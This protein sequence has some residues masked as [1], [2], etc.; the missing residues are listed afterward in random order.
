MTDRL[1]SP[2]TSMPAR[3]RA[4]LA[5][6]TIVITGAS[7]G[8]GRAAVRAFAAA[9]A[10]VMMVGRNEAKTAAAARTLMGETGSRE[11]HWETADLSRQ[12][13]VRE[14]A[15]RL[16]KRLPSIDVLINNAGALYL[17]RELTAEGIERTVALNHLA[18]FSLTLLLLP[19]LAACAAPPA[20]VINVSSRAHRDARL[21]LDDLQMAEGYAGWRQYANSKLMNV[22]ATRSLA[23]RLD[24]ARVVVHA[25]HPGVVSTRFG[26]N[27]GRKGRMLR[28]IMDVVSI[29]P[30]AGADT[31][32]WLAHHDNARHRSGE[33]WVKRSTVAASDAAMSES[34][35]AG[36]WMQTEALTG[37]D[38]EALIHT[39]GL[40]RR[41]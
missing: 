35:A 39:S 41:A 15:A 30:E 17:S 25:L 16:A 32:V 24:P 33:Y 18:Y 2:I 19:Q 21:A 12:E 22:L 31:V 23:Q 36:L 6:K 40:A 5:G 20:R 8:I 27:N 38:A 11:I 13:A 28:R 7:D 26:I 10:H 4:A 37:L 29:T 34:L 9:G 3:D 14:L 1:L